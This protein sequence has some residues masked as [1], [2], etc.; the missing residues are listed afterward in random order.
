MTEGHSESTGVDITGYTPPLCLWNLVEQHI[1]PHERDEIKSMLGTCAVEETLDL[2]TELSAY[3]E[4]W[5]ECRELT[6]MVS[7]IL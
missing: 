1:P 2:H 4:I 6:D 7:F 5:R 3:L